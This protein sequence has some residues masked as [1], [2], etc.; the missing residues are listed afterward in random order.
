MLKTIALV[1]CVASTSYADL[2]PLLHAINQVEASGQRDNVPPGD[3]GKAI[4]PFQIH[5]GYWKDAT[6][7][8]KTIGGTYGDCQTYIYSVKI[9]KAYLN[10]YGRN[11]IT[12]SN[13]EALARIHNGGPK[14][15]YRK[16]T[17]PYWEMVTKHL[18]VTTVPPV[19]RSRYGNSNQYRD[20]RSS[21]GC[22]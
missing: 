6:G 17:L 16:S 2:A 3:D 15:Y 4:G 18:P 7:F 9:V 21:H 8:D 11:F 20:S 14:G 19:Q 5:R 13:W 10:R 12:E 1:V 22:P